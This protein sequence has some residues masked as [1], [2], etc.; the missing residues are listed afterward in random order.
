[1]NALP[2]APLPTDVS[3]EAE[4][5]KRERE[6]SFVDEEVVL[7]VIARGAYVRPLVQPE[8]LVLSSNEDDYA[9]WSIPVA[10]PFRDLLHIEV[11]PQP[12]QSTKRPAPP[13]LNQARENHEAGLSAP[14]QGG[15]RWWMFG[16]SGA[17]TCGI[18]SV[19][20]LTLA[21]RSNVAE[22]IANYT[23]VKPRVEAVAQ[24]DQNPATLIK[25]ASAD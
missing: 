1:M 3:P 5:E 21:Q 8:G 19:T 4:M 2:L 15:H 17:L 18:F 25:V 24:E 7:S 10:S 14:H 11:A 13:L 22:I 6:R 12:T 9:G 20:L 16:L 23:P